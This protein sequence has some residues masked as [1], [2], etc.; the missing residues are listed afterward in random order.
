MSE[1]KYEVAATI[2]TASAGGEPCLVSAARRPYNA[3]RIR[4]L[5]SVRDLTWGSSASGV[6]TFGRRPP[7]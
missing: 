7:G 2:G 1:T 5:G 6:D 4:L 3:P